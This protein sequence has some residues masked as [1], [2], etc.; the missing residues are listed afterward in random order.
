MM[1]RLSGGRVVADA[2][3][4]CPLE[5][6]GEDYGARAHGGMPGREETTGAPDQRQ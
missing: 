5:G 2:D 6:L 1:T 3:N 4:S